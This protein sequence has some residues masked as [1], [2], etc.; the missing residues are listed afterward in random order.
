MNL[1]PSLL[2]PL[3]LGVWLF[4]LEF[5]G[6]GGFGKKEV[7]MFGYLMVSDISKFLGKVESYEVIFFVGCLAHSF[8][9]CKISDF[10]DHSLIGTPDM[11][12][13]A[14]IHVKGEECWSEQGTCRMAQTKNQFHLG[15]VI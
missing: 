6:N 12:E 7:K 13:D 9:S 4:S 15:L 11:Q 14:T 1:I 3:S 2:T 10:L 8:L 5:D